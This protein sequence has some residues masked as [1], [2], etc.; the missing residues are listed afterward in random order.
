MNLPGRFFLP[1]VFLV[2]LRLSAAGAVAETADDNSGVGINQTDGVIYPSRMLL[3]GVGMGEARVVISVD[4][5]GR[6]TD[7]LVIGYTDPAFSDAAIVA[8][9]KWTYE[10][11]LV[12]GH[13]RASRAEVLFIF[14][15][16]GG[17]TVQSVPQ[18]SVEKRF[19]TFLQERYTFKACQLR[20]LDR[21]PT[22][23]QVISPTLVKSGL[24][25]GT[26]RTVTVEFYID[27]QGR[28]RAPAIE[29]AETDDVYAAAAVAAV[30]QWRFE[31]PLRKGLP[32]LVLARQD[33]TFMSKP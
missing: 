9:K 25:H 1:L 17:V 18:Q 13:A 3:S 21:I 10:P 29:R 7:S 33:F 32:V 31:P 15:D 27:Q 6:L 28:V 2:I 8:L 4:A 16:I 26:K 11:A 30:E 5:G 23:L 12:H 22:P 20:D 19:N 14:S 24:T